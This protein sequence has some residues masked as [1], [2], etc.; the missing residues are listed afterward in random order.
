MHAKIS[1]KYFPTIKN[2]I[3]NKSTHNLT[4]FVQGSLL[5]RQQ[6]DQKISKFADESLPG[7]LLII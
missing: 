1:F 2:K 3:K 5:T 7:G 6:Q 4:K